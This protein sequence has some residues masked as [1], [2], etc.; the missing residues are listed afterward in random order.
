MTEKDALVTC[1]EVVWCESTRHSFNGCS[2][3]PTKQISHVA[4]SLWMSPSPTSLATWL[5]LC[6]KDTL[7]HLIIASTH[8]QSILHLL[9]MLRPPVLREDTCIRDCQRNFKLQQ[10]RLKDNMC[11]HP[12]PSFEPLRRKGSTVV[13]GTP[14]EHSTDKGFFVRCLVCQIMQVVCIRENCTIS[15]DFGIRRS[16][17]TNRSVK[18]DR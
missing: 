8:R 3:L 17:L 7:W 16:Y 4:N 15:I 2:T 12:S 5:V 10:L 13:C 1:F 18:S 9:A 11:A 14:N 6:L